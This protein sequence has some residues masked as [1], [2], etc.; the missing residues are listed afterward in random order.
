MPTGQEDPDS[1]R[2]RPNSHPP[3]T[4]QRSSLRK[5]QSLESRRGGRPEPPVNSG[6]RGREGAA[7]S[8]HAHLAPNRPPLALLS[9]RGRGCEAGPHWLIAAFCP[10]S[11]CADWLERRRPLGSRWRRPALALALKRATRKRPPPCAPPL[12]LARCLPAPPDFSRLLPALSR[13]PR[14]PAPA[15][16]R[17][18]SAAA[19]MPPFPLEGAASPQ[20]GGCPSFAPRP[21]GIPSRARSRRRRAVAARLWDAGVA[22]GGGGLACVVCVLGGTFVGVTFGAFGRD[23]GSAVGRVGGRGRCSEV[24]RRGA[25]PCASGSGWS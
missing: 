22:A 8:S 5:R 6:V 19:G 14:A 3:G 7:R 18:V 23:L 16:R 1:G 17:R 9:R 20:R 24:R 2:R 4:K 15:R 25:E 11:R 13:L 21:L 10:P 12:G